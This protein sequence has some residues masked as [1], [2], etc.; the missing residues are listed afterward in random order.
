MPLFSWSTFRADAVSRLPSLLTIEYF[1]KFA[2]YM[3]PWEAHFCFA[4]F[5]ARICSDVQPLQGL[6]SE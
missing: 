5:Q 4:L 2:V 6:I 3:F 1:S